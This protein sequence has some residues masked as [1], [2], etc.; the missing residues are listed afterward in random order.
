MRRGVA[1][2]GARG[3]EVGDEVTV[4][5]RARGRL[6]LS[7]E[8]DAGNGDGFTLRQFLKMTASALYWVLLGNRRNYSERLAE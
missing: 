2:S 3:G 1:Q 6:R 5:C 7:T 4:M 8:C